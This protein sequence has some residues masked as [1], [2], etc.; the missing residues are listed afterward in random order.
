MTQPH[1][2]GSAAEW[3]HRLTAA[4]AEPLDEREAAPG[5]TRGVSIDEATARRAGVLIPVVGAARPYIY[6][7]QRSHA[8]RHHPGQ[9]SFPGGS[10]EA[11]DR[12]AEA[13]ALREAHEEIGLDPSHVEIL[14]ELPE[15]R[16]ITGFVISPF[17]GWVAP[18]ARVAPDRVE[19]TR[20][21]GVP[22]AHA[23]DHRHFRRQTRERDGQVHQIYS[24]DYDD[25]HI[26]GATAGILYGLLQRLSHVEARE[27]E[28]PRAR[29]PGR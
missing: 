21:F 13:A 12:N 22:L 15:Y 4:L 11:Y 26:W 8:L 25:D 16:T 23:L 27:V 20:I 7:T 18:A 10:M 6:F 17:V 1:E 28:R 29:Q 3:R 2:R 5:E 24:I 14:G 19:V 9:I